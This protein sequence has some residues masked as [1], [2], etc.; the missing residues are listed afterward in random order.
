MIACRRS[1][2]RIYLARRERELADPHHAAKD[3]A[4]L[5]DAV[6]SFLTALRKTRRDDC[7][8]TPEGTINMYECKT[9]HLLRLLPPRLAD[10]TVTVVETYFETRDEEGA[11]HS[12]MYK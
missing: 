3:A 9:G 5:A 10:L 2:S 4:T 6:S 7:S 8:P 11:S 1:L 12:T